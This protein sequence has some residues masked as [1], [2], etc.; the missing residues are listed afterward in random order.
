MSKLKKTPDILQLYYNI[1]REQEA[2]AFI[3]KVRILFL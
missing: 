2:W 1:I 3:E